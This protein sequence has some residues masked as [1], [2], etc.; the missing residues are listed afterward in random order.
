[1]SDTRDEQ[2]NLAMAAGEMVFIERKLDREIGYNYWKK[3]VASAFWSQ[4]STPI[5]LTIT[6]LTAITTA[7]A[8]TQDL[9]SQSVYSQ[10]AIISLIITTLNTFFRPH[11]QYATTTEYMSKWN[12]IGVQFEKE[13]YSRKFT[14]KEI[15]A[16][17]VEYKK[18][19]D[20]VNNLRKA[21]GGNTVNFITDLIFYIAFHTCIRK[22]KKWLDM[23]MKA[24]H[25]A[26]AALDK[27]TTA[28]QRLALR[29]TLYRRES[30]FKNTLVV[31]RNQNQT[32]KTE[33]KIETEDVDSVSEKSV[34]LAES[35]VETKPV[36][37]S[38]SNV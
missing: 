36:S 26:R 34:D 38:E 31:M 27:I 8:N 25:E 30:S 12:D 2:N 32:Q 28:R 20:S 19:L 13:Y 17:V 24:E 22:Y 16:R 5:N 14:Q 4:I 29:S 15:E 18:L 23:D 21:E 10:L 33:G 3:Y 7:Q 6:F 37:K 1:M 9:I 35:I 11:T